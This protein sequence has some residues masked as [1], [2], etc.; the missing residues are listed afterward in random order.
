MTAAMEPVAPE[1]FLRVE[2]GV[3]DPEELA[4]L[5]VVLHARRLG[6][7]VTSTPG[8]TAARWHRLERRTVF[9]DPRGWSSAIH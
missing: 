7:A 5:A 1:P 9:T 2:K 8:P 6:A 3:A 4:V